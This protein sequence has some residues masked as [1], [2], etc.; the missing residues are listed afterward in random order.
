MTLE[1]YF[2]TQPAKQKKVKRRAAHRK[3][4]LE[5]GSIAQTASAAASV[6]CKKFDSLIGQTITVPCR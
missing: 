4:P 2:G 6:S 3:R 5:T 1:Q